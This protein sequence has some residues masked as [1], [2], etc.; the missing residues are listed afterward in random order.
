M[1]RTLFLIVVAASL[2]M[3]STGFPQSSNPVRDPRPL[4]G[5]IQPRPTPGKAPVGPKE[6]PDAKLSITSLKYVDTLP[7]A[8]ITIKN[9]GGKTSGGSE[10]L[11]TL[12][13]ARKKPNATWPD[14]TTGYRSPPTAARAAKP[15]LT[16]IQ[17][18]VVTTLKLEPACL[19]NSAD[20]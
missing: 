4:P 11:I 12:Y 1:K 14:I 17:W 19:M 16:L 7:G 3:A 13:A 20:R 2:A 18:S 10:V 15:S 9:V 6:L 5:K 8:R